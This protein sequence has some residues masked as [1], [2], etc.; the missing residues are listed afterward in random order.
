MKSRFSAM[1]SNLNPLRFEIARIPI[2]RQ[3][4]I[5]FDLVMPP[6][7]HLLERSRTLSGNGDARW[8]QDGT[9]HRE[10]FRSLGGP[11]TLFPVAFNA[12]TRACHGVYRIGCTMMG[13]RKV[14][15][16]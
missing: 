10:H 2:E 6:D 16:L 5:R 4:R 9:G 8:I 12:H 7:S 14:H 15:T 11:G 1:R 3:H 13:G